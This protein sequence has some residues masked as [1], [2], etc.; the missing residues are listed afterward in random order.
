MRSFGANFDSKKKKN[1]EG[2]PQHLVDQKELLCF[3]VRWAVQYFC[4]LH[5]SFFLSLYEIIQ[6]S[7]YLFPELHTVLHSEHHLLSLDDTAE[8][9]SSQVLSS[10]PCACKT[11]SVNELHPPPGET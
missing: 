2:F 9:N 11:D 1:V 8:Q 6:S 10:L 3:S 5:L 4:D 7:L